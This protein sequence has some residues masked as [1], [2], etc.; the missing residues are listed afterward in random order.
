M[1]GP[2]RCV[3]TSSSRSRLVLTSLSRKRPTTTVLNLPPNEGAV[4][5]PRTPNQTTAT[6]TMTVTLTARNQAL[7][8]RGNGADRAKTPRPPHKPISSLPQRPIQDIVHIC[9]STFFSYLGPNFFDSREITTTTMLPYL[10]TLHITPTSFYP[11]ACFPVCYT[12]ST[13]L[14]GWLPI[15]G[16]SVLFLFLLRMLC[17]THSVDKM[18]S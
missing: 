15:L 8:P 4:A 11:R 2:P 16:S 14:R 18:S 13:L 7:L 9:C 12:Y 17:C 6:K 1:G 3:L 5:R 10:S